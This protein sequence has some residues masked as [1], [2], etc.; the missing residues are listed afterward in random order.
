MFAITT[1]AADALR[2]ALEQMDASESDCLRLQVQENMA[3]LHLDR[4]R[5]NDHLF[6]FGERDVLVADEA[7][8]MACA[9]MR[10]HYESEN[11][12]AFILT[13]HV[14]YELN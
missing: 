10:L 11:D 6:T 2:R 14:A 13:N 8:C 7:T 9:G 1:A 12:A 3:T 4:P 5:K